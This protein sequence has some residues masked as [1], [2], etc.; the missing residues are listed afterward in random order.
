LRVSTNVIVRLEEKMMTQ[1]NT[2]GYL[3][4]DFSRGRRQVIL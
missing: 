1:P 4:V 2:V 3:V